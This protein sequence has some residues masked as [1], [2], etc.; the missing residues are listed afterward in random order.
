MAKKSIFLLGQNGSGKGLPLKSG[1][2]ERQRGGLTEKVWSNKGRGKGRPGGTVTILGPEGTFTCSKRGGGGT[3]QG[4]QLFR[5]GTKAERRDLCKHIEA[6]PGQPRLKGG[7]KQ[8]LG[9]TQIFNAATGR[10][11]PFGRPASGK[12]RNRAVPDTQCC[13]PG[14]RGGT[15]TVR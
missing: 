4:I 7:Q 14:D 9:A 13:K 12:V 8:V 2:G 15:P 5:T 11:G 6:R 10:N 3:E 1:E